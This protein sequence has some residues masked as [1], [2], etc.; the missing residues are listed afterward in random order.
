[1]QDAKCRE[2]GGFYI[3]HCA[4]FIQ[5][6]LFIA[7]PVAAFCTATGSRGYVERV[8]RDHWTQ[9]DVERELRKSPE[10]RHPR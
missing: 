8:L 1:M 7:L 9:A 6:A 5:G 10:Y 3:F 2:F 4:S